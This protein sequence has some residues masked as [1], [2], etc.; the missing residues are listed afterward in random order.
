M[1]RRLASTWWTLKIALGLAPFL[2]GLDKFFNVLT[3]WTDYLNP[4]ALE[5]VPV[6]ADVFMR[7]VGIIEMIVG[8]AILTRWTRLGAYLAACW[9]VAIAVNLVSMEKFYDVAVR[10]VLLA[11]MAFALARLTTVRQAEQT[12]SD[13]T[14]W[15]PSPRGI[16]SLN[17]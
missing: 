10:D 14:A 6:A 5:F 7:G 4:K 11:V 15:E 9:L 12:S 8:L 2:A 3:N 1:D 16:L 17:L 13:A